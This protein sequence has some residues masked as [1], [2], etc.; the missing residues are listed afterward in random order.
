MHVQALVVCVMEGMKKRV[1]LIPFQMVL[2][3]YL[4]KKKYLARIVSLV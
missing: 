1:N 3:V 2:N 4:M